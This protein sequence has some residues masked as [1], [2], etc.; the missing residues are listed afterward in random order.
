MIKAI[1]FDCFGVLAE[2]GWLPLKRKYVGDNE[3]LSRELTDL[4]KQNEYGMLGNRA[5]LD[6]AANLIG[7][8]PEVLLEALNRKAPNQELFDYISSELKPNY[9]IGLLSN[10]NYD[11]VSELFTD[12]QASLF[13]VTLLSYESRLTKP[14]SRMFRLIAEKLG[15]EFEE[16]LYVDDVE[17]YCTAADILG[18]QTIVY[19]SPEQCRTEIQALIR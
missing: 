10:A 16:C 7:V 11:V 17:R 3:A 8:E 4:G 9:K 15:A 2:D 6:R 1:I 18:M 14:D 19:K 13:D 5:Y 12:E